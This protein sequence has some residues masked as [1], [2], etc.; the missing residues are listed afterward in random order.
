MK[1]AEDCVLGNV[2]SYTEMEKKYEIKKERE[3][4]RW[5]ILRLETCRLERIKVCT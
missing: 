4:D 5:S 1:M 2:V 3:R